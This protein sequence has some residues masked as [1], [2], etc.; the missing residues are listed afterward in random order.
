MAGVRLLLR[1][2]DDGT[3][4]NAFGHQQFRMCSGFL[5]IIINYLPLLVINAISALSKFVYKI[6]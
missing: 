2:E 1:Y 3:R 5:F 6:I 4:K